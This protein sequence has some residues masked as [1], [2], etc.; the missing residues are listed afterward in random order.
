MMAYCK[1]AFQHSPED[2]EEDDNKPQGYLSFGIESSPEPPAYDAVLLTI[3][4]QYSLC[5]EGVADC[6]DRDRRPTLLLDVHED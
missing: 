1:V 4:P 6:R 3:Q 5:K 2:T